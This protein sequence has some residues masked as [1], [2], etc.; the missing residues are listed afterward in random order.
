MEAIFGKTEIIPLARARWMGVLGNL[1][2]GS[3]RGMEGCVEYGW[4]RRGRDPSPTPKVPTSHCCSPCTRVSFCFACLL[5]EA[6][7]LSLY[8]R[9]HTCWQLALTPKEEGA[10]PHLQWDLGQASLSLSHLICKLGGD[11]MVMRIKMR[12]FV[13]SSL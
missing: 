12:G 11:M 8:A 1:P 9:G 6:G 5:Q 2:R 3:V 4:S 7:G 13:G 10:I